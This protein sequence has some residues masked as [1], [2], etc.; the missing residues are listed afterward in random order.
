[1]A[2][3]VQTTF[4]TVPPQSSI[5]V[6]GTLIG[7]TNMN[8][9]LTVNI[10]TVSNIRIENI[11]YFPYD[12][13]YD[14]SSNATFLTVKLQPISYISM[15]TDP[16][17]ASVTLD[18]KS[19]FFTPATFTTYAGIHSISISMNGYISKSF[20]ISTFPFQMTV[21]NV[22]L[23]PSGQ[24]SLKSAPDG[25]LVFLDDQYIGKT[26]ISTVLSPGMHTI[27]VSATNFMTSS[28]SISIQMSS[29]PQTLFF[30]LTK[31]VS[32]TVLSSPSNVTISMNGKT[33]TTPQTMQI[34]S[35]T[36]TYAASVAYFQPAT[37]TI[38]I[39]RSGT[40][41]VYLQPM[42]ALVAFSSNPQG[43]AVELNG[44]L[45]GQTQMT[46]QIPYGLYHVKMVGI[47][48][49]VWFGDVKVDHQVVNVYGDMINAGMLLLN[50]TPSFKTIAHI[51]QIWTTLP[52]TLTASVG[53]YPIEFF[54]PNYPEK[55]VYVKISGGAVTNLYEY[56]EPMASLFVQSFPPAATVTL[57]GKFIAK[58]PIFDFKVLPGT[59][60]LK[61]S[62]NDGYIE[63]TLSIEGQQTYTLSFNDPTF[64]EIS[65]IS[66]PD[67]VK[68]FVDH[69][70]EGY[71]PCNVKLSRGIHSYQ[72]YDLLGNQ[73][74]SGI[75]QTTMFS[76][77]TY[78]FIG[79]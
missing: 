46:R 12:F 37:G 5:Y 24:V 27:S 64:V 41:E 68:I 56:L 58:T 30:R 45:I 25:A 40:Y 14:P 79:G 44:K 26:P 60:N 67:P 77:K 75:L 50:A 21:Q 63:R 28:T 51:G 13:T 72:V 8:G 3:G 9:T 31:I 66:Y 1:M 32:V 34:P 47:G 33:F 49:K 18:G 23:Q 78:F 73:I 20:S 16:K 29:T 65:F 76:S 48:G 55:T 35:G 6:N 19:T 36:Y 11:G 43:A 10:N 17:G 22:T 39:D 4:L 71:T 54:N 70:D 2:M 15:N 52:A 59:Y 53:V 61:V 57:N 42:T 7:Q 74:E 69:H 38:K 62:W